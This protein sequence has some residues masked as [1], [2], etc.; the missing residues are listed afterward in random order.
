MPHYQNQQC[1]NR[2]LIVEPTY[3]VLKYI[4]LF[5]SWIYNNQWSTHSILYN[6]H[7]LLLGLIKKL[8]KL[9]LNKTQSLLSRSMIWLKKTLTSKELIPHC[10]WN[11]KPITHHIV[12]DIVK[13]SLTV[14][15]PITSVGMCWVLNKTLLWNYL[16]Q[17]GIHNAEKL[18]L[19][20][21]THCKNNS[22]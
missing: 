20:N 13:I 2:I 21:L 11:L 15:E 17:I 5:Y 14:K 10:L 3:I 1:L 4:S 6:F 19:K 12:S 16:R 22:L 8:E 18:L 9:L 7:C